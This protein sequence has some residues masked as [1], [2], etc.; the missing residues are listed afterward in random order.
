VLGVQP[1]LLGR[2]IEKG[3]LNDTSLGWAAT[4]EILCMALGV[5][6]G[7]WL[8]ATRNP[9]PTIVLAALCMA[10][11]NLAT[12]ITSTAASVLGA[13]GAAGLAEG[14]LVAVAV[15]VTTYSR[16]P[17][18]ISAAFLTVSAIPQV[19]MSYLL[20]A[21]ISPH[22]GSSA[23]FVVM[24]AIGIVC[25]ALT[26]G[27]REPLVPGR[28][29]D[30]GKLSGAPIVLFSLA[31][32]LMTA[33]AIG[34]CWS[35]AER[36][37]VEIGLTADQVGM[38]ITASLVFQVLGSLLVALIGWRIS[39]R[40]ALLAGALLQ[41]LATLGLLMSHDFLTMA[42]A[43]SSFGFLWQ[44]CLPFASDLMVSVDTSRQSAPL[45]MPLTFVGLSVGPFVASFFV[46][47][48]ARGALQVGL[49]I[50]VAAA[51]LYGVLFGL[52]SQRVARG[53]KEAL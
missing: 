9:R 41:V 28:I 6:L 14:L 1:M 46:S 17:A 2:L 45:I 29:T 8:L 40:S 30:V 50:F 4:T 11:A 13:R 5:F 53:V 12:L 3:I 36:I 52:T 15:L 39:Y 34:A 25:A 37:G 42:V 22:F 7:P 18:R 51:V 47:T 19:I 33:S 20:P 48:G 44:G 26:F 43:L 31:T 49:W 21:W 16:S 38:C 24:G 35:Y 27:V 32:A 23:G 10:V